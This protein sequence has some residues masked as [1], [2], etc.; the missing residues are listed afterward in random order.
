MGQASYQNSKKIFLV[1]SKVVL[2]KRN[3]LL[4]LIPTAEV[5]LTN[6][7]SNTIL[8]EEELPLKFAALTCFRSE[9]GSYGKDTRGLM[10]QH[11]FEKVELVHITKPGDSEA[12]WKKCFLMQRWF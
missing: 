1:F 5:P 11:Q 6:L 8:A 3:K 12:C 10:R 9:A 2:K 7:V 4:F